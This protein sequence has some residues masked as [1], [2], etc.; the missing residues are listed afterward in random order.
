[1]LFRSIIDT[2]PLEGYADSTSIVGK[3]D[4]AV[5]VAKYGHTR[6][7]SIKAS[8]DVFTASG[9]QMIGIVTTNT[10]TPTSLFEMLRPNRKKRTRRTANTGASDVFNMSDAPRQ[11][12]KNKPL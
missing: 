5:N 8:M 4:C 6:A 9:G 1:M 11:K 7:D 2:P 12:S 3:T 10:P